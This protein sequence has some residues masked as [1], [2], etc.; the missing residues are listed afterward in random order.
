METKQGLPHTKT[1]DPVLLGRKNQLYSTTEKIQMQ[2]K[3]KRDFNRNFR[4]IFLSF[5]EKYFKSERENCL[6]FLTFAV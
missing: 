2:R 4:S 5:W 6:S 3:I 1:A